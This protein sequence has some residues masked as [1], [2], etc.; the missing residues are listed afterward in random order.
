MKQDKTQQKIFN[1]VSKERSDFFYD[2]ESAEQFTRFSDK[3]VA[4]TVSKQ[5]HLFCFIILNEKEIK[6]RKFYNNIISFC[7]NEERNRVFI[8]FE[9][10]GMGKFLEVYSLN[11]ALLL[12]DKPLFSCQIPASPLIMQDSDF[13]FIEHKHGYLWVNIR[14]LGLYNLFLDKTGQTDKN[15]LKLV[16]DCRSLGSYKWIN[17]RL[18]R[19]FKH[20][21]LSV[22]DFSQSPREL[23]NS[24]DEKPGEE[25]REPR[26]KKARLNP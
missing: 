12:A 10:A 18:Y 17:N 7:F 24:S 4:C 23:E 11:Q 15:G 2:I 8:V 19:T 1:L 6:S 26:R 3:V 16:K 14:Y 22:Y 9:K 20:S 5:H 21:I 25:V 13:T